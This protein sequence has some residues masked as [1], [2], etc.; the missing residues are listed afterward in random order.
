M[1]GGNWKEMFKGIETNDIALVEYYLKIGVDANYQHPEFLASP[2]VE[3]I[4]RNHLEIAKLLLE[5]NA[6]PNIIEVWGKETPLS[7][8][9]KQKNNKAIELLKAYL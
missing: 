4:R 6:N 8:A 5:N 1:S 2:L 7:V 9:K 3:S